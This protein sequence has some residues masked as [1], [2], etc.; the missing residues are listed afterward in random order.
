MNVLLLNPLW[1]IDKKNLWSKIAGRMPSL[2]LGYIA[3][4]LEKSGIN[5]EIIDT[6]A[7]KIAPD[8]LY[9]RIDKTNFDFVGITSLTPTISNAVQLS[10]VCRKIFPNAKIVF[11]GVHPTALPDEALSY[12]SVDFV[13]K[14]EGEYS[15]LKLVQGENLEKIEGLSYRKE[16]KYIHNRQFTLIEDLD[17]VPFPAF[18]LMPMEMYYPTLGS[19]KNLPAIN[20][21][22][23]RGCPYH[24]SFCCRAVFGNKVRFRSPENV[25]EEIR[26]LIEKFKIKEIS[27]YDDNFTLFKERTREVCELIRKENISITWSC[28]TRPELVD[29]KILREMKESGCHQICYGVESFSENV[30]KN[31]KKG[32]DLSVLED[33]VK[34]TRD[35][36]I[37]VR[38]SFILGLPGETEET[39]GNM[40]NYAIDLNPDLAHFNIIAPFPGTEL[41]SWAKERNYITTYDYKKYDLGNCVL[42]LP[43]LSPEVVEKC[44]REMYKK[45]YLRLSYILKRFLKIRT[46]NDL[47]INI[48]AFFKLL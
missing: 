42:N 18:H 22:T 17:T 30:L 7:E 12:D 9:S 45:F 20:M 35:A 33:R 19:F 14:G 4:V 27:F 40:V 3:S 36:G 29:R 21:I 15:F 6:N 34:S 8:G 46:L 26:F 47:K 41:F 39:L 32:I 44:Y 10:K 1:V 48:K 11:G 25:I 28:M 13:I 31:V 2:G 43:T 37:Q 16:N 5:V 24:C 23:I 38:L